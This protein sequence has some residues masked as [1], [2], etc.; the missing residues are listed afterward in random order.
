MQAEV[1][2]AQELKGI[3]S[4]RD[5]AFKYE[6]MSEHK[7]NLKESVN[8]GVQRPAY[9]NHAIAQGTRVQFSGQALLLRISGQ[10]IIKA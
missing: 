4:A 7:E 3:A 6:R 9:R 5:Q 2:H 1:K 10:F 8:Y